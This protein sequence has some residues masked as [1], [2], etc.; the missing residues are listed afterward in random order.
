EASGKAVA[1]AGVIYIPTPGKTPNIRDDIV[2]GWQGMVVSDKDSVFRI[3]VLPG[4]GHL[5]ISGPTPDYIHLEVGSQEVYNGTPGGQRYSPDGLV[6]L[7][8]PAKTDTKKVAVKLRRGV[9]VR[10][11]LLGPDG[12]PVAKA[13]VFHRQNVASFDLTWRFPAEAEGGRF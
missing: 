3:P 4:A 9:T 5:L 12:K 8:I 1:G 13:L 7:N 6:N 2:T 10:G 11:R